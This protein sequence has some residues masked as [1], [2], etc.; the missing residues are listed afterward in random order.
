MSEIAN[1]Q[2]FNTHQIKDR[3]SLREAYKLLPSTPRD[4]LEALEYLFRK[5]KSVFPSQTTLANMCGVTRETINRWLKVLVE[6]G[7]IDKSYRHLKTCIYKFRE[8]YDNK[9]LRLFFLRF[10]KSIPNVTRPLIFVALLPPLS[11]QLAAN[12]THSIRYN[13]NYP[14]SSLQSSTNRSIAERSTRSDKDEILNKLVKRYG[15]N[16]IERDKLD[17]FP[18]QALTKLNK[19]PYRIR[20][21]FT[22]MF[23][24]L[25]RETKKLKLKQLW[26]PFYKKHPKKI[27]RRE[28]KCT[29]GPVTMH[30]QYEAMQAKKRIDEERQQQQNR[31]RF[32]RQKPDMKGGNAEGSYREHIS[33][34]PSPRVGD[35][36]L[37]HKYDKAQQ[38]EF[39]KFRE[40]ELIRLKPEH[41]K[42]ILLGQC[43][44]CSLP[45]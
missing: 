12:V 2:A 16:Q 40:R 37:Y 44:E 43:E 27:E 18:I 9:K 31:E 42:L 45:F 34:K 14:C 41:D 22:F 6:L 24:T 13:Y 28:I 21:V 30:K 7:F 23:Q 35:C 17:T 38:I 39:L 8:W 36:E 15:L 19:V 26:V 29:E 10:L 20:K 1:K 5:H 25:Q 32:Q 4:I 33:P 3:E 11:S